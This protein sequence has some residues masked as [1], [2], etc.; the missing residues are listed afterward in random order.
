MKVGKPK[1]ERERKTQNYFKLSEGE[2]VFRILPPIGDLADS[3]RWA[4]YYAVHW[5]YKNQNGK[6]RVF[7]S[8]EVYNYRN[9]MVEIEDAAKE[10]IRVLR[11]KHDEMKAANNVEGAKRVAALLKQYS[12]DKKWHLNVMTL[13]GK[14]G[15]LKIPHKS[16]Q[17]LDSVIKDLIAKGVD[18][19]SVDNGRFF[20]FKRIGSGL[21]TLHQVSV[22]KE[23]VEVPGFGRMEREAVSK[24]DESTLKRLETEA[25]DLNSMY[26]RPSAEV[27]AAIVKADA[28]QDLS[29]IDELLGVDNS[30][31][32][33]SHESLAEDE[34]E[35]APPS[36]PTPTVA[37][38]VTPV[39][40]APVATPASAPVAAP[41]T[42]AVS[43]MSDD[44]FLRMIGA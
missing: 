43:E 36:T 5:G 7:M 41:A 10:R 30:G 23:T 35:S 9:K 26:R 27:V 38:V 31:E 20:V 11:A 29:K 18:P 1:Y 25:F 8:P 12:L 28:A 44:E 42:K 4:V 15:L 2:S 24:L 37:P 13:D 39:A 32:I 19:L 33:E 16:K 17:A 34:S 3:G 14:I 21:D 6:T 40:A 22:Y